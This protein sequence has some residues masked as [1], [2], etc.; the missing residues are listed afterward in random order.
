[1]NSQMDLRRC[2]EAAFLPMKCVGVIAP[3][4][5]MT[6]RIFNT[7]TGAEEF[8]VTCID[9]QALVTI[10]DIVRLVLEVKEG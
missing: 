3:D 9:T 2:I 7:Y 10:W 6:I 4:A 8:P 1:M 5:S